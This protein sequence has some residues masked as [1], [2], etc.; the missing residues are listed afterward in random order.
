MSPSM[1][2]NVIWILRTDIYAKLTNKI[3][4]CVINY[5]FSFSQYRMDRDLVIMMGYHHLLFSLVE[6]SV[7]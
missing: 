2:G 4:L 5:F 1:I 3:C 7:R 6:D